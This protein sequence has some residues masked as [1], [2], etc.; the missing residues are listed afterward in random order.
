MV[1]YR[2]DTCCKSIE[3]KNKTKKRKV[4]NKEMK[5]NKRKWT[6]D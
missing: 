1:K 5:E 6:K 3:Y 4:E 2:I